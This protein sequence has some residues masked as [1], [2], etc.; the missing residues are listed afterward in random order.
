MCRQQGNHHAYIYYL[1]Q[2]IALD[3]FTPKQI[4]NETG[5]PDICSDLGFL[6]LDSEGTKKDG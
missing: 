1:V 5:A 3:P 6:C 4:L 2:T